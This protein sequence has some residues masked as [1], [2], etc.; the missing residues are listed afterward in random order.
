M[1][2]INRHNFAAWVLAYENGTLDNSE[3]IEMFQYLLDTAMVWS[4]QGHYQRTA[5][6]LVEQGAC[7]VP[8]WVEKEIR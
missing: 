1:E 2:T 3:M 6:A 7:R 5:V 8:E 4:L